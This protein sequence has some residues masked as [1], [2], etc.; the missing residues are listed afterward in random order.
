MKRERTRPIAFICPLAMLAGNINAVAQEQEKKAATDKRES[1]VSPPGDTFKFLGSKFV[2]VHRAVKRAPYSAKAV[3]ETIQTLS[4]GNQITQRTEATVYRDS[5]GRTRREQ[6][7]ET[8]G[9]WA[10]SGAPPQ[11]V[12]INDP[13][14][15]FSYTLNLNTR[16]A[17]EVGA[18]EEKS[19]KLA[20]EMA[21][22]K[23]L[24][25]PDCSKVSKC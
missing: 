12:M 17:Y 22:E 9:K 15:G 5:E 2:F 16:T 8:V 10:A 19:A 6:T 14:T 20:M 18:A 13:V 3:T 11:I 4:D 1:E 24:K 23:K 25:K 21:K 7:L